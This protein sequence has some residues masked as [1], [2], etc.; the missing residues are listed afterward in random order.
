MTP[1]SM[2]FVCPECGMMH[3]VSPQSLGH[4]IRCPSCDV[5]VLVQPHVV[6]AAEAAPQM[7]SEMAGF[8]PLPEE[9]EEVEAPPVLSPPAIAPPPIAK[10]PAFKGGPP[11]PPS[12]PPAEEEPETS[13]PKKPKR[14]GEEAELD[15]TPMVDCTFQLL[16]FFMLT[17]SFSLQK[18]LQI[19][20]PTTDSP[21]T[22]VKDEP[23]EIT[24]FVTV[25]I[26]AQSTYFVSGGGIGEDEEE[27]PSAV[28]LLVKLRKARQPGA[29]GKV[30]NRLVVTAHGDALHERVV[31]AIDAGNDIGMEEV[32]L[33]T[34]EDD[35]G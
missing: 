13:L 15:M 1:P 14:I 12:A 17:A 21:G 11:I 30:P 35:D 22:V 28:E 16:I 9:S 31:T 24:D 7:T 27:A 6:P 8:D 29:D 19:P 33:Q 3:R 10:P 32:D 20:K 25:R 34:S 4:K 23:E 18:S 26:D 2:E 5:L